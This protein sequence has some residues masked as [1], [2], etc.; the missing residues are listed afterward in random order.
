MHDRSKRNDVTDYKGKDEG[1][2]EE[3]W[4][5]TA[6]ELEGVL[7]EMSRTIHQNPELGFEEQIG[8]AHV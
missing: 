7:Q 6:K 1:A 2:M 5:Q 4:T 3:K 8:R